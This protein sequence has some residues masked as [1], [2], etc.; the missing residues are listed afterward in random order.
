M[1]GIRCLDVLCASD[2]SLLARAERGEEVAQPSEPPEDALDYII[3]ACLDYC[4]DVSDASSGTNVQAQVRVT[5]AE[6]QAQTEAEPPVVAAALRRAAFRPS[7]SEGTV[8]A[9]DDLQAGG[10]AAVAMQRSLL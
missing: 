4:R 2:V 6:A 3:A 1:L 9:D 8:V 7:A 10:W 5:G